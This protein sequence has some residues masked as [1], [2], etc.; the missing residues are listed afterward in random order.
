MLHTAEARA[1]AHFNYC[2]MTVEQSFNHKFCQINRKTSTNDIGS[3]T[4]RA[5]HNFHVKI[6]PRYNAIA[7]FRYVSYIDIII[8]KELK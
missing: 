1:M 7:I 6:L 2:Y 8:Q 5:V 4:K 3:I